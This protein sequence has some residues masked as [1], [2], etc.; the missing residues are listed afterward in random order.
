MTCFGTTVHSHRSLLITD[1]QHCG[2]PSVDSRQC[3]TGSLL[4]TSEHYNSK[5]IDGHQKPL[6]MSAC[7]AKT[8]LLPQITMIGPTCSYKLYR[9]QITENN[10]HFIVLSITWCFLH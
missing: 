8:A 4:V 6:A 3:W 1:T 2:K 7:L 5:V 10:K 9:S